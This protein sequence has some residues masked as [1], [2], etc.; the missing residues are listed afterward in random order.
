MHAFTGLVHGTVEVTQLIW[1]V[2]SILLKKAKYLRT[3]QTEKQNLNGLGVT[4]SDHLYSLRFWS[5][6]GET[7]SDTN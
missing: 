6:L 2:S 3:S 5:T 7:T 4:M 1:G